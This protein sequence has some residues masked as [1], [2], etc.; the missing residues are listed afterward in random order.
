MQNLTRYKYRRLHSTA[1]KWQSTI[2][3]Y[4]IRGKTKWCQ[5][6]ATRGRWN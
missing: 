6:C 5:N 1:A 3:N 4:C 2:K